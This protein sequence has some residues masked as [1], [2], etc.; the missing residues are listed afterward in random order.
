MLELLTLVALVGGLF[1]FRNLDGTPAQRRN[2]IKMT[3]EFWLILFL[4]IA[5]YGAL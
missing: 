4:L 3:W 2:P 5:L 1:F